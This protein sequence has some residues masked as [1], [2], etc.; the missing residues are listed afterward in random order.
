MRPSRAVAAAT[1]LLTV[2]LTRCSSS[3]RRRPAVPAPA[4]PRGGRRRLAHG[5]PRGPRP[6]PRPAGDA[7]RLRRGVRTRPA[8][9]WSARAGSPATGTGAPRARRRARSSPSPSRSPAPWS[10]SRCATGRCASATGSRATSRSGAAPRRTASPCATCCRTTAVATGRSTPTTARWS[11]PQ[12]HGVRRRPAAAARA[13]QRVGLQQRGHPG[14]RGGAAP[15][16]RH[17]GRP[18]RGPAAVR[19]AGHDP[20]PDGARRERPVDHRL[21]RPPDHLPGPGPPRHALPRTGRCGR[22]ADPDAGLRAPVGRLPLDA[23]QRRLRLPVVAQPPRSAA[24]RHR[25]GRRR[26]AS[27]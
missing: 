25:R 18:V 14:A 4:P 20:H 7:G 15:R 8:T 3:A 10:A 24:R 26:R 5:E 22:A 17:A 6:A 16:D 23:A 12:P 9:P 2:L 27:R 13:R 21:L 1:P 11:G 19:A